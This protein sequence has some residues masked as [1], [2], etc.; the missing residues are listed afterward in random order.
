MG[1]QSAAMGEIDRHA[2]VAVMSA[3][4]LLSIAFPGLVALGLL[5]PAA[6]QGVARMLPFVPWPALALALFGL[7]VEAHYQRLLT[8]VVLGLEETARVFMLFTAEVWS[9]DGLYAAE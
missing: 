8:G 5:H 1:V 4:L 9:G 7:E 2:G 3:A 6:R